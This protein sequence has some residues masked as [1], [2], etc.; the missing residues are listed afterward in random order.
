MLLHKVP[1][2][3]AMTNTTVIFKNVPLDMTSVDVKR[4]FETVTLELVETPVCISP[5]IF[6]VVVKSQ[7]DA[8]RVIEAFKTRTLN[9]EPIIMKIKPPTLVK[10]RMPSQGSGGGGGGGQ[11]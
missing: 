6:E 11:L 10:G 9:N 3:I 4:L 7:T 8:D 2:P 1:N 5:K